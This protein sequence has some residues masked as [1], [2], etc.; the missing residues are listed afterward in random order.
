MCRK[1]WGAGGETSVSPG[2][3]LVILTILFLSRTGR[4]GRMMKLITLVKR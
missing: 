1:L 4:T 2:V 3:H